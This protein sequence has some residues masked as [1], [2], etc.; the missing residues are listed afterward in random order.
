MI[1]LAPLYLLND[2][3]SISLGKYKGQS[4][5][6][7]NF[8]KTEAPTV[9]LYRDPTLTMPFNEHKQNMENLCKR[10]FK[11]GLLHTYS[12]THTKGLSTLLARI[13]MQ[14][15]IIDTNNEDLYL[16]SSISDT[17]QHVV[18][19]DKTVSQLDEAIAGTEAVIGYLKYQKEPEESAHTDKIKQIWKSSKTMVSVGLLIDPFLESDYEFHLLAFRGKNR[20]TSNVVTVLHEYILLEE[21]DTSLQ[22]CAKAHCSGTEKCMF[23]EEMLTKDQL[24]WSEKSKAYICADCEEKGN[25]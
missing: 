18:L 3:M 17:C 25:N 20:D 5:L 12:D 19:N 13:N 24:I 15:S 4:E 23:H 7:E 11:L 10:E 1:G 14:H 8:R 22:H 9:H 21:I 6:E 2:E 16:A